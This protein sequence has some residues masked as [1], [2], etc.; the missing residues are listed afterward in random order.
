MDDCPSV[1]TCGKQTKE[2]F[3]KVSEINTLFIIGP[4]FE[5]SSILCKDQVYSQHCNDVLLK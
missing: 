2:A 1:I 3:V 5:V 4:G